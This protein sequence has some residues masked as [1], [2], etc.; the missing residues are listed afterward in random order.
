MGKKTINKNNP[1][2]SIKAAPRP[3][4]AKRRPNYLPWFLKNICAAVIAGFI[5]SKCIDLQEGYNWVCNSMLKGNM[6][7]IKANRGATLEQRTEF[8]LG[9]DY[10]YLLFIR[11]ATPEDAVILYPSAQ[12]FFP[13]GIESRFK[14]DVSNRIWALRFLYPRRLVLAREMERYAGRI[15]HVAIVNGRG[16]ERLG[17]EAEEMVEFGIFPLNN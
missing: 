12:D 16:Y 3:Q 9:F 17:Y 6:E 4:E 2:G 8:K 13:E 14:Q 10:Q 5:L 7:L 11:N 1:K 15:T